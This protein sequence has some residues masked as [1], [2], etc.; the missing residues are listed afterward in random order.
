MQ[1]CR[2]GLTRAEVQNQLPMP[3]PTAL[4]AAQDKVGLDCECTLLVHVQL[5]IQ[6]NHQVLLCKAVLNDFLSQ[7]LLLS[8]LAWPK[9]WNLDFLNFIR[10]L[11]L[12]KAPLSN[13][14]R[15]LDGIMTLCNCTT[16]LHVI[17]I[18]GMSHYLCQRWRYWRALVPRQSPEG[19]HTSLASTQTQSLTSTLCLCP[20]SV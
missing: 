5:F 2:L 14:S 17:C 16:K 11:E 19:C 10:F 3:A 6:K 13:L 20:E 1:H 15:I 8:L 12:H 4:D 9:C 7:H 18:L